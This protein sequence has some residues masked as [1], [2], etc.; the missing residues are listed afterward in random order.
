[1]RSKIL[2]L[3]FMD[4]KGA[5]TAHLG[6]AVRGATERARAPRQNGRHLAAAVSATDGARR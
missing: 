2:I 6:R 5:G 1:M 3:N 4:F